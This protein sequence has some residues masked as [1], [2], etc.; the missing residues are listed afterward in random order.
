MRLI[1]ILKTN[2]VIFF[3]LFT[4]LRGIFP[5]LALLVIAIFTWAI[6]GVFLFCNLFQFMPDQDYDYKWANFNSVTDGM[7]TLF[8]VMTTES[9]DSILDMAM[10]TEYG[11]GAAAYFIIYVILVRVPRLM[12]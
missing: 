5:L 10:D 9:W 6:V 2:R 8:Q 12:L 3:G 4:I 11:Y 1:T 7:S